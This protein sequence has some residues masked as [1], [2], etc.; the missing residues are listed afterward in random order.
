ME[1]ML[2]EAHRRRA[3]VSQCVLVG[4]GLGVGVWAAS[5]VVWWVVDWI[6]ETGL[7]NLALV[8]LVCGAV[9]WCLKQR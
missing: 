5:G 2:R 3:T 7:Q 6:R 8:W 4:A 9:V 1:S